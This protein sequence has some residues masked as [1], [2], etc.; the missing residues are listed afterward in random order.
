[1]FLSSFVRQFRR[2]SSVV[3]M[4]LAGNVVAV[5]CISIMLGLGVGQYRMVT[6]N[7]AYA[8]LTID[9][10]EETISTIETF[11]ER[12]SDVVGDNVFNVLYMSQ[13][14]D[15]HI[16]IG[17]QGTDA[18]RWFPITSGRFFSREDQENG[19]R[20]AVISDSLQK[21][22]LQ[23]REFTIGN[24]QYDLVGTG[25][26]VAHNISLA[27]SSQSEIILFSN[28]TNL[29]DP[30]FTIIPYKCYLEEFK[31]VQVL[32]HFSESTYSDLSTYANVLST[33]FPDCKVF[34]PDRNSDFVLP[35]NLLAYGFLG[36]LLSLISC[37]TIFQL[38][39]EWLK[40]Y[41][42]EIYVYYLLGM[43]K[44]RCLMF[45]YGHWAVHY[46]ASTLVAISV[47]YL[48]F[49][50]LESVYAN[51]PPVPSAL[52]VLLGIIFTLSIIFSLPVAL[53]CVSLSPKE[54]VI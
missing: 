41:R 10:G 35:E 40:G 5:L 25:W 39:R 19:E 11:P 3:L 54:D 46:L 36:L 51:Y 23:Q 31:P 21:N 26:I 37:I 48:A 29:P 20:Y 6:E 32:V 50:Y 1:M 14:S 52:M 7:N 38:M 15:N 16:L 53:T 30:Y 43:S 47:H 49:P 12:L 33:E 34:L 4:L 18:Q 28:D 9:L 13:L 2:D 24:N 22:N 42:K 27:L 8:T 44:V 45:V 17:W